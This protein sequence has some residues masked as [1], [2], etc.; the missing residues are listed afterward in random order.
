MRHQNKKH[1][2][3]PYKAPAL[4]SYGDVCNLTKV[5]GGMAGDG[6][7]KPKTKSGGGAA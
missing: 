1:Q 7:H 3:R 4:L 5:K 2:K 6:G